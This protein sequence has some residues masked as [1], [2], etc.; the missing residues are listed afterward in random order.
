VSKAT[1]LLS[2]RSRKLKALL[3]RDG[4]R[5]SYSAT[6]PLGRLRAAS[7]RTSAS[8]QEGALG[9][10]FARPPEHAVEHR[11]RHVLPAQ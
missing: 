11:Y 1:P 5:P 8:H 10:S 6:R 7:A 2:F 4:A 9:G 3:R